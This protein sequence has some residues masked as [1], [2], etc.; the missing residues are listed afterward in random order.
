MSSQRTSDIKRA[1]KESLMLKEISSLYQQA[2]L[3]NNELSRVSISRVQLSPDKG[4]CWIFFYTP[5]GEEAFN[6]IL[7]TLKLYRPSLRKAL[8]SR[9]RFRYVPDLIFKFDKQFDKTMRV[10][11]LIEKVKSEDKS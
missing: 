11:E 9:V 7:E 10:E 3:D 2:A 5:E 8:A 1:Q 4:I 6:E